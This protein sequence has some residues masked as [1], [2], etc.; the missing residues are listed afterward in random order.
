MTAPVGAIVK[1]YVDTRVMVLEAGDV[2]RTGTGRSYEVITSRMQT[3]GKWAG[4]RQHLTAL[5]LPAD[6]RLAAGQRMLQI[7]WYRR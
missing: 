6:Y 1:L 2:V 7:R 5:V 3:R 4:I